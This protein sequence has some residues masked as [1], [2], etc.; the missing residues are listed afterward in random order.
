MTPRIRLP[1]ALTHLPALNSLRLQLLLWITL[2]V[3]ISLFG[4]SAIE[5]RGHEQAMT[6]MVQQQADI[7]AHSLGLAVDAHIDQREGI[8]Q[9]MAGEVLAGN[10]L[11]LPADETFAAG[12]TLLNSGGTS[13]VPSAPAWVAHTDVVALAD[14]VATA[15]VPGLATIFD[16]TSHTWLLVQAGPVPTE[17]GTS[18]LVGAEPVDTLLHNYFVTMLDPAIF[19]QLQLITS[20][21]ELL[22]AYTPSLIDPDTEFDP[23][24]RHAMPWITGKTIILPTGWQVLVYKDWRETVAPVLTF[25]NILL[26]TAL[27]T[28][29]LAA[30]SAY[31]A[32]RN[33]VWPLQRLD[34]MADQVG[35]G[36]FDA[37][38][39]P[40]GGIAEIEELRLALA[41][42]TEQIRQYQQD[43]QSYIGAMTLGQEDE[44]RRLAREL[45]DETVQDLI[46]LNQQVEMVE[47][48]LEID[49]VGAAE[50]LK[51]LRPQIASVIDGLRR[52]IH[53]LR[54]LYLEDLGFVPA[55]E[56][57]VRQV[58]QRYKL[59]YEFTVTG[60][61]VALLPATIQISAFRIVQE[62]L[63]NV[64][65]HAQADRVQVR[66]AFS[67]ND[68]TLTVRDNGQGFAAPK[69]PFRLAQQGHYGLLGMKERAELNGGT[70]QIDSRPG[71]GT[72]ITVSLPR[73][74]TAIS[75]PSLTALHT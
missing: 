40:V 31:F 32:L 33:I 23:T 1:R 30:L 45:H 21:G 56:M 25:G 61:P 53:A 17:G 26:A 12:L 71:S 55:I 52:Q 44:R 5:V 37:I 2:P 74:E 66:L 35:W 11:S 19:A 3:A 75:S 54:P 72:A 27:V 46:A 29:L 4:M 28:T 62:A 13:A 50:R 49:P 63:Q 9:R 57:L 48:R 43:L 7:I 22:Y 58:T 51:E 64:V 65:K 60:D 38:R 68:L 67:D 39:Q 73:H 59:T 70:L 47:R 34:A 8:L 42:M 18:V 15:Q 24:Q 36:N 69:H 6:Q 14:E 10:E 41:R 20:S 16:G